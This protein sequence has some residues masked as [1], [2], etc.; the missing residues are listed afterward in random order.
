MPDASSRCS[1]SGYALK[2]KTMGWWKIRNVETG[3]IDF[4][5]VEVKA[6]APVEEQLQ[7]QLYNGD[8]PADVMGDAIRKIAAMYRES[9]GRG[10]KADELHACLNF[11]TNPYLSA[12]SEFEPWNDPPRAGG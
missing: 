10:P 4:K 3:Q 9:F 7:G 8:G 11:C 1:R 6:D 5:G 2:E 12:E